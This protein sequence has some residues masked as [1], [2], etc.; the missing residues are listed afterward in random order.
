MFK[1]GQ[2]CIFI[3]NGSIHDLTIKPK[4]VKM[5]DSFLLAA[6]RSIYINMILVSSDRHTGLIQF[7]PTLPRAV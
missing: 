3:C 7:T 2:Y 4:G 6:W 5:E 1:I